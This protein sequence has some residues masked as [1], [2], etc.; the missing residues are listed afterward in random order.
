MACRAD[1]YLFGELRQDLPS[2]PAAVQ[3][4]PISHSVRG[5]NDASGFAQQFGPRQ[6]ARRSLSRQG[7]QTL[8]GAAA[9]FG[10]T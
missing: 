4:P 2:F 1:V 10:I 6:S 3:D 5:F 8:H 7:P 9:D